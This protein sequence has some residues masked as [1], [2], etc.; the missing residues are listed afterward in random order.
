[1][2]F[3]HLQVSTVTGTWMELVENP[4]FDPSFPPPPGDPQFLLQDPTWGNLAE[5]SGDSA[6][7]DDD[8]CDCFGDFPPPPEFSIPPPPPPPPPP[9]PTQSPKEEAALQQIYTT[10]K[11]PP[12]VFE[13]SEDCIEM[14]GP[15]ET[16]PAL[17]VA[18]DAHARQRLQPPIAALVVAGATFVFVALVA[19]LVCWR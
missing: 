7:W 6:L 19:A 10:T 17:M 3:L 11:K 14:P 5:S 8:F 13:A 4:P 16:C 12:A 9:K 18:G 15:A 2:F 1:M